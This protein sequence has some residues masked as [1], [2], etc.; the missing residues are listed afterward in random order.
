ML[1]SFN[2]PQLLWNDKHLIYILLGQ[3]HI[4]TQSKLNVSQFKKEKKKLA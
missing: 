2:I 3:L 4:T 1:K